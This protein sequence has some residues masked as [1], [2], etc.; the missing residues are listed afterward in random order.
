MK[1]L[2]GFFHKVPTGHCAELFSKVFTLYPVNIK[3]ANCFRTHN[4]LT[5]Y[6]LGK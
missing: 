4:E 2:K 6:P 3:W 1:E 5:M